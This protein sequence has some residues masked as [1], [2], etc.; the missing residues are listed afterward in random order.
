MA[1][2]VLARVAGVRTPAFVERM[3]FERGA[4]LVGDQV[5]PGFE[6]RPS[7]SASRGPTVCPSSVCGCRRGSNPGLR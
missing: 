1:D 6:P 3:A 7:L 5:S 2:V 4:I